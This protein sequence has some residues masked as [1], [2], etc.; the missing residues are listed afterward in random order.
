MFKMVDNFL[1]NIYSQEKTESTE[2]PEQ[3][4]PAEPAKTV[5]S[6]EKNE[7]VVKPFFSGLFDFFTKHLA[8]S[9]NKDDVIAPSNKPVE[10]ETPEPTAI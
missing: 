8:C 2:K 5:E 7:V 6:V 9:T 3:A 10:V 4:K 1:N